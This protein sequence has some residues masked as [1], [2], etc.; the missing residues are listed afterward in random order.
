MRTIFRINAVMISMAL[1][2]S[3]AGVGNQAFSVGPDQTSAVKPKYGPAGNPRATPLAQ[4][5]DFFQTKNS[6]SLHFWELISYYIPQHNVYS[7]SSAA[8]AMVLNAARAHLPKTSQDRV[9][10]EDEL[11]TRVNVDHWKE[12]LHHEGYKGVH[13]APIDFLNRVTEAAFKEYGFPHVTTEVI[14]VADPSDKQTRYKIVQAL[15][16]HHYLIASFDQQ[17]FTDDMEAGHFAPVAA[18]DKKNNRVLI[19][20]PD[21]EYFEPYWISFETFMKGMATADSERKKPRGLLVITPG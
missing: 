12:R 3:L 14:H 19:L 7:C 5:H 17:A 18:Y 11:V 2:L 8:L 16:S 6:N 21:R 1:A 13:G 10:T 15:E 20:D 9:I 4:E